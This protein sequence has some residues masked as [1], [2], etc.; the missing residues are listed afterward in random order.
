MLGTL[1]AT[2]SDPG[3]SFT[4]SILAGGDGGLFSLS[5][6]GNEEIYLDDGTLHFETKSTYTVN[7]RVTDLFG[8]TYDE[9]ITVNVNNLGNDPVADATAG[10]PYV[11][12]EG[13]SIT[14]DGS[15][16]LDA[17]TGE[18][19]L[20]SYAWDILDNGTFEKSGVTAVY[21][22]DDLVAA[23]V[24]SSGTFD[25]ALRVT[26]PGLASDTVVFTLTVT[27]INHEPAG[28]DNTVST[29]EES[30]YTFTVADFGFSDSD[31]DN[32]QAIRIDALPLNGSLELSGVAVSAG[33]FIA[34]A[35]I[36]G[37][38]H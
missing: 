37:G 5:G 25:V 16:S 29:L 2:D 11:T 20:L 14:F 3:E 32:L 24:T 31:G 23:G 36:T 8:L 10:A 4:Y 6:E 28:A 33:D 30:D 34:V 12:F 13:G 17:D 22:W 35:E 27:P 15:N 18:T 7:L 19:A 1:S 38:N 21:D 26:D 9:T